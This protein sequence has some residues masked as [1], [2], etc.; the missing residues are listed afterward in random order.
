MLSA[1]QDMLHEI[2]VEPDMIAYDDFG[3]NRI[4]QTK[5]FLQPAF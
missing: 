3:S 2:G 1:M 4:I 5:Y